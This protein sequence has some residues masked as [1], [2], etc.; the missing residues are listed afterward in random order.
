MRLYRGLPARADQPVA[1]TIGNFDGHHLGHQA[2]LNQVVKTARRGQGTA[3][4]LTFAPHPVKILAPTADLRFLTDEREK[5]ARFEQAG[6]DEV[7]ARSA[8]SERLGE[9]LTSP[10]ATK[11]ARPDPRQ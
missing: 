8:F 2:L 6:I 11:S 10:R 9:I 3:L 1:L 4:V 5:L 7:L